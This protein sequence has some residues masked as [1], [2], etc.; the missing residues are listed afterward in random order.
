MDIWLSDYIIVFFIKLTHS[1]YYCAQN[2]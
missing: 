1:A 2:R